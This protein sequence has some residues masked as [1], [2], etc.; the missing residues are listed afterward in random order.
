MD[1]ADKIN[2]KIR[3]I[4]DELLVMTIFDPQTTLVSTMSLAG[5]TYMTVDMVDWKKI[6]DALNDIGQVGEEYRTAVE[7]IEYT[8][9][10]A[11]NKPLNPE[12]IETITRK[13]KNIKNIGN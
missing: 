1:T 6:F 8:L 11:R 13:V 4:L 7:P 5:P 3:E 2:K 10:S 12:E 9:S